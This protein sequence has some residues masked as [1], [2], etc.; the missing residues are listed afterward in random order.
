M[1]YI[2]NAAEKAFCKDFG[3]ALGDAE[4]DFVTRLE[5]QAKIS[6]DEAFV[7]FCL[8]KKSK[9]IT[10]DR[11]NRSYVVKHGSLWNKDV[12]LRALDYARAITALEKRP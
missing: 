6:G 7:V 5:E 8:Y 4:N 12:I 2:M 3:C 11:A 10:F 1:T 9:A